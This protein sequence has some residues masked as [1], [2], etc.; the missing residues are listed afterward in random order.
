MGQ[1]L[2]QAELQH[3]TVVIRPDISALARP[4]SPRNTRRFWKAKKAAQAALPAI[5]RALK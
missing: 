5:Q 4:T 1:K 2:G 3:A